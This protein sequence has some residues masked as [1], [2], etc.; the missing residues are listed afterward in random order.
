MP[1]RRKALGLELNDTL[2]KLAEVHTSGRKV[3]LDQVVAH[4]LPSVWSKDGEFIEQ[5]ELVQS[6]REALLGRKFSTRKVHLALSSRHVLIRRE[7]VPLMGRRRL[8]KWVKEQLI[9]NL[10][11]SYEEAVFDSIPLEKHELEN[12]QD[13][14]FVIASKKYVETFLKIIEWCGLEPV[15]LD[16]TSLALYRW[17]RFSTERLPSRLLT[18]HLSMTG[19][20]LAC[21]KD[22]DMQDAHFSPLSMPPF[23][24]GPDHPQ[25]DPLK[26]IL[27]N[28]Q[29]VSAYGQ[30]L[31]SEVNQKLAEWESAY[32]WS[33]DQWVLTGDGIDFTLLNRWL[34]KETSA[35]VESGPT[36]QDILSPFLQE[37]VSRWIGL[38]MSVPVGLLLNGREK[39]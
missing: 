30:Q 34:S 13:V 31:L 29:E 11:L 4:P 27:L 37:R 5:E 38:S 14:M 16:L 6:V 3:R 24:I 17:L 1:F 10:P 20:E 33:P 26:P 12:E 19:V 21:F 2:L 23:R 28:E 32:S 9:P 7:R 39:Q 35:K 22:G 8:R 36:P 18:L 25:T 15:S